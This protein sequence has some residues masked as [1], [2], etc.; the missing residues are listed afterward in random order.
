MP[1]A[2]KF[3]RHEKTTPDVDEYTAQMDR[4]VNNLKTKSRN[5]RQKQI[6]TMLI[7]LLISL[8][9]IAGSIYLMLNVAFQGKPLSFL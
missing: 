6:K 8:L 3:D 9:I 5:E 7:W 2:K 4:M 1:N